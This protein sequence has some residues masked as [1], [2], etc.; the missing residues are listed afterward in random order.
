M[1]DVCLHLTTS[2]HG[3]SDTPYNDEK[4]GASYRWSQLQ[5]SRA[6]ARS[7]RTVIL[8]RGAPSLTQPVT[9]CLTLEKEFNL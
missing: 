2:S 3:L 1:L 7:V 4:V 5:E 9:V 8:G 6:M